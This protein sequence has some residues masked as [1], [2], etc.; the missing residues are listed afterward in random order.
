MKLSKEQVMVARGM[1]ERGTS[2][3]QL[4]GQLGVTESTL[5]YRLVRL[6]GPERVDGRAEQPTALEGLEEVVEAIQSRPG[7][8]ATHGPGPAVPGEGDL[9]SSPSGPQ[10]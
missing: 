9:R 7:G 5:R 10:L 1:K 3:R 4:A 2:V 6:E 8:R